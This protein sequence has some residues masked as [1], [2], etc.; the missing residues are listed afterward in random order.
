MKSQVLHTVWCNTSGEAAGEIWNWSLLGVKGFKS[1]IFP[2]TQIHLLFSHVRNRLHRQLNS[3]QS[4]TLVC[5]SILCFSPVKQLTSSEDWHCYKPKA[6]EHSLHFK[7]WT[8]CSS[9]LDFCW[10]CSEPRS[11]RVSPHWTALQ[12]S[13][14]PQTES[15]C[16]GSG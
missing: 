9:S 11:L 4:N 7:I 6:P 15:L 5:A 16:C 10:F 3:T 13:A 14:G 2:N 12:S 1:S 8:R